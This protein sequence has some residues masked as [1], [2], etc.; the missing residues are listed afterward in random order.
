[1]TKDAA[2]NELQADSFA[3]LSNGVAPTAAATSSRS[4][5][6]AD[7]FARCQSQLSRFPHMYRGFW[8]LFEI[9][10]WT[11]HDTFGKPF[12]SK[13]VILALMETPK[14]SIEIIQM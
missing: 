1:M 9:F 11:F 13:R 2:Q 4:T 6:E 14:T 10:Q 8:G 7:S 5:R 12:R 3:A